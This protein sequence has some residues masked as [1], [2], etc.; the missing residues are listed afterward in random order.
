MQNSSPATTSL[1]SLV[2]IRTPASC[3]EQGAFI[4]AVFLCPRLPAGGPVESFHPE[5]CAGSSSGMHF[6]PFW[7]VTLHLVKMF[8]FWGFRLQ[9]WLLHFPF[10]SWQWECFFIDDEE[11][12]LRPPPFV[13]GEGDDM[14]YWLPPGIT[15]AAWSWLWQWQRLTVEGLR[16]YSSLVSVTQ[17][18]MGLESKMCMKGTCLYLHKALERWGRWT[19][20]PPCATRPHVTS[21]QTSPEETK[22]WW[23]DLKRISLYSYK[24]FH[25]WNWTLFANKAL[26]YIFPLGDFLRAVF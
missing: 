7:S 8:K 1:L 19:V 2:H 18:G 9:D 23:P 25:T 6:A 24:C 10:Y 15:T 11:P 20:F 14:I 16:S 13:R 5:Q 22:R 17:Q 3:G 12:S 26:R 4:T 21:G